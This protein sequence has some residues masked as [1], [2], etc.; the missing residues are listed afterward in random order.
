MVLDT[1]VNFF[2]TYFWKPILYGTGYNIVNTITY[3][4]AF[5]WMVDATQKTLKVLNISMD[6]FIRAFTPYIMLGGVMR[7]LTDASVYPQSFAF[8]T[9]GIYLLLLSFTFIDA[10]FNLPLGWILLAINLTGITYST[11]AWI[12][13]LVSA[14]I[15]TVLGAGVLKII[16]QKLDKYAVGA[17]AAHMFDAASTFVAIDFF[18]YAE[19][20]VLAN[21]FIN[22]FNTAL[23]MFPLKLVAL[24]L[25]ISAF[26]GIKEKDMRAFFY[27]MVI[28]LGAGPGIR[29]T[30]LATMG[31]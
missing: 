4:L 20:H 7:V 23:V 18:H 14:I 15:A 19:Q 26:N 17:L 3:A 10:F 25:V 9:P 6:R 22:T 27:M 31:L 24:A 5:L 21:F 16:G 1:F 30:L 29:N 28:A 13:T 8:V 2:T 11:N 12:F